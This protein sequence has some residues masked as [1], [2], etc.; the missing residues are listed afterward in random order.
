MLGV[1][2]LEVVEDGHASSGEGE[3]RHGHMDLQ[4]TG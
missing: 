1:D 4:G 2:R 3:E